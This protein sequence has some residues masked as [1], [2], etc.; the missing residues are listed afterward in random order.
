MSTP[1]DTSLLEAATTPY[2]TAEHEMLRRTV[3]R[4]VAER[5]KPHGEAWE[6]EGFVP[7]QVLRE[8]GDLGLLGIRYSQRHGGSG[9]D[10]LATVVLAEVFGR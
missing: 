2:F 3:R 6:E 1:E 4:F 10:T 7:R 8:M 5:V 9:L